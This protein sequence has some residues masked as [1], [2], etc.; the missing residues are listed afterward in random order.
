MRII[1]MGPPGVGKGTQAT[2]LQSQF[3]IPHI[4][5]GDIFRTILRSEGDIADEVRKYLDEGLLVPDE[6]TN[7]VVETRFE[8]GDDITKGFIFD[9]YPRN[10]DQ[11][12]AFSKYLKE[13]NYKLD[14]VINFEAKDEVIVERLSGRRVCPKCGE[15][16]HLETKKPKVDMIW[17]NDQTELIQRE[18]DKPETILKRLAVYHQQTKP[19]INYYE[20]LGLLKTVDGTGT[21]EETYETILKVLE[22]L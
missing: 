1:I 6:L 20:K 8:Q 21:I 4:S 11:A 3:K 7:R 19:L 18:D 17:D 5:T 16:Y 13:N 15:T 9:G 2:K 14:I 10:V 22:A 12:E